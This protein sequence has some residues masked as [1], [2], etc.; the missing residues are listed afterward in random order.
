MDTL[1]PCR[2]RVILASTF[3]MSLLAGCNKGVEEAEEQAGALTSAL[4]LVSD[5]QTQRAIDLLA[6]TNIDKTI[7]DASQSSLNIDEEAFASMSNDEQ[8]RLQAEAIQIVTL[9]KQ[10]AYAQ[11]DKLAAAR[12]RGATEESNQ[13]QGQLHRLTQYLRDENRLRIY[14]DLGSAVQRRLE[15]VAPEKSD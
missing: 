9:V 1:H 6:A 15:A 13:L 10:A 14:Q 11:I 8:S 3:V 2:L 4:D 12:D 7:R 5:G